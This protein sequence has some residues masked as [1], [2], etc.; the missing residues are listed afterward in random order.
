MVDARTVRGGPLARRP[1]VALAQFLPAC[2]DLLQLGSLGC[3]M[4]GLPPPG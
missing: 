3:G 4:P 2:P 1:Q